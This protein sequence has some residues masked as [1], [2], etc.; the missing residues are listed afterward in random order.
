[1]EILDEMF[2]DNDC[3][4]TLKENKAAERH[5]IEQEYFADLELDDDANIG[6]VG[7]EI[8]KIIDSVISEPKIVQETTGKPQTKENEKGKETVKQS[9]KSTEKSEGK[10]AV[11]EGNGNIPTTTLS[12]LLASEEVSDLMEGME[13]VYEVSGNEFNKNDSN[14]RTLKENI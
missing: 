1:M 3:K 5:A 8:S 9:K 4:K 11:N 6:K 12:E 14:G 7:A 2:E 13:P 10:Q